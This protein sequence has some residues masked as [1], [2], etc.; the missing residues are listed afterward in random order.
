[1]SVLL[2]FFILAYIAFT[3]YAFYDMLINGSLILFIITLVGYI[4]LWYVLVKDIKNDEQKVEKKGSTDSE[5]THEESSLEDSLYEEPSYTDDSSIYKEECLMDE[6]REFDVY[7]DK[8][9][10]KQTEWQKAFF[11]DYDKR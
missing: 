1:M 8:S 4:V 6:S 3:I 11:E 10:G 7:L 9:I 5:I 2:F